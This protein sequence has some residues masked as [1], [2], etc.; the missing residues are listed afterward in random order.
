MAAFFV[1]NWAERLIL[2]Y[3]YFLKNYPDSK[4]CKIDKKKRGHYEIELAN[5]IELMF[6]AEY[7]LIGV[8][9]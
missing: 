1:R 5:D 9:Y 3:F 6:D 2:F 4:I 7:N 8:D